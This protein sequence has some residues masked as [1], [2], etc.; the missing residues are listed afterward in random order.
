MATIVVFAMI[1]SG[2]CSSDSTTDIGDFGDIGEGDILGDTF[3]PDGGTDLAGEEGGGDLLSDD[4]NASDDTAQPLDSTG[5]ITSDDIKDIVED[6]LDP[7]GP[8]YIRWVNPFIGSGSLG[9]ATGSAYP[10]ACAPLG[11]V[12]ASPDTKDK[13]GVFSQ[14]HCGGYKYEEDIIYGFSH[15]HL[16]GTGA[17]G[18]GYL[19]MMPV[20]EMTESMTGKYSREV[21]FT[22]DNE[23]ATPG[24]YAVTLLNPEI[25]VEITAT[26]RCAYHRFTFVDGGESGTVT[27][28]LAAALVDGVS[29][30]ATVVAVDENTVVGMT[31]ARGSFDG[32]SGGTPTYFVMT[33]D[34]TWSSAG[35]WFNGAMATGENAVELSEN[36]TTD[37]LG[38]FFDFPLSEDNVVNTKICLSF[39][40]EEGAQKAMTAEMPDWDFSRSLSATEAL[41]EESLGSF[42]ITGGTEDEKTNFYTAIYHSLQMPTTWGDVDGNYKG[43][44]LQIHT[45]ED[46]TYYT[47]FSLW[48]TY[49]TLHPLMTLV[50]PVRQRDMNRSLSAMAV[51]GGNLP[52][53]ALGLGDSGSMIG[54][55]GATVLAD[56]YIKG[57]TDFDVDGAWGPMIATADG[58][59]S[60]SVYGKRDMVADYVAMGYVPTESAD[61]NWEGGSVSETLEYAFN[62]Y[63]IAR[64]AEL[65][66]KTGD[67]ERFDE[68]SQNFRNLF[69]SESGFFRAKDRDGNWYPELSEFDP[70]LWE[71]GSGR[72][73]TEASA[74]QYL[75]YVPHDETSLR[76]LIGGDEVFVERLDYFMEQAEITFDFAI[77]SSFYFHGNEPDIHA[78][79]MFTRAGRPDL[80]QKWVRWIMDAAY[81]NEPAGLIGNDDAGTLAAWYVFA[82]VGL[83]PWPCVPGYYVTSPIF[84]RVTIHL[85]GGDLEIEAEGASSGKEYIQSATFNDEPLDTL[86]LDHDAI[87]NGGKLVLTMGKNP[88]L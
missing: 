78:P 58:T 69:D 35:H 61:G 32:R 83:G 64:M 72:E 10:G 41:W 25:R 4:G 8:P 36:E 67:I 71:M 17:A 88:A 75:W 15:T 63:C 2:G 16:H 22:H 60:P 42:E 27:L 26:T 49:R 46:W 50:W 74:W 38:V 48:D 43:F 84:D 39:V 54:Q 20:A 51:Q 1:T 66:G 6:S 56:S 82:G 14:W 29:E 3:N 40:S 11:M 85:A 86:W 23:V 33:F 87:V 47:D 53:W 37:S 73:Y 52:K 77:P 7:D 65:A 62:D 19:G 45:A 13:Y 81:L 24:Y 34:Q 21:K 30:G 12:K 59:I 79:F 57:V 28:D 44:D 76:E 9:F 70:T 31:H 80:T 55:H 18:Y 68:R 5:D